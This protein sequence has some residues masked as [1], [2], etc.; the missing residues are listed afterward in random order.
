MFIADRIKNDAPK[1]ELLKLRRAVLTTV[2]EFHFLP[3]SEIM[4]KS[5]NLRER[6]GSEFEATYVTALQRCFQLQATSEDL[7]ATLGSRP[8]CAELAKHFN[9]RVNVSSGEVVS[10]TMFS[11]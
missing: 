4:Y 6:I 1:E 3:A 5:M 8:S 7:A 11:P 9:A 10:E 2:M